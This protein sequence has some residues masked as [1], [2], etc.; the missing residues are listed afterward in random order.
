MNLTEVE[1]Q[2]AR[3]HLAVFG[4]FHPTPG[5]G[6]AP[7]CRT[8]VLL[9]PAEPGFWGALTQSRHFSGPDPV[10]NWSRHAI[11]EI[12]REL[13]AE[14]LFPFGGPPYQPFVAWALK[15]GRTWVSRV[16]LLIHDEAGLFASFRG[17]LAFDKAFDLAEET[18]LSPCETCEG[19]PCQQACPAGALG[20]DGYDVPACHGF[21]DGPGQQTCLRQGC[22]VRRSCPVSQ[23]YWQVG[24]P[25]RASYAVLSQ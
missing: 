17:A 14:A 3:H 10:D 20:A 25:I 13:G 23:N 24:G 4:A 15:T 18:A 21:L 16:G 1:Q 5:D 2:S 6:V 11:G 22:A 8:L 9:G 19:R 12:A 7:E